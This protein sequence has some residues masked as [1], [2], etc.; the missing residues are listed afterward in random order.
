MVRGFGGLWEGLKFCNEPALLAH[1]RLCPAADLGEWFIG[2]LYTVAL[3]FLEWKVALPTVVAISELSF[4]TWTEA[5]S[6]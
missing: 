6:S 1:F 2:G 3:F 4:Q 5:Y